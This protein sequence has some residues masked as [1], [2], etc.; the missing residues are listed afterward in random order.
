[1]KDPFADLSQLKRT[2]VVRST[3]GAVTTTN[4]TSTATK[5]PPID[6]FFKG[7]GIK[8]VDP[9][10]SRSKPKTD[11]TMAAST[12]PQRKF[13]VN[14]THALVPFILIYILYV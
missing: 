5:V 14:F 11:A 4:T 9:F 3:T 2:S 13:S 8:P 7:N 10:A 1:M 6:P 12:V